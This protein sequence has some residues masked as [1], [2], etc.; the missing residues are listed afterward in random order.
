MSFLNL[1]PAPVQL[2]SGEPQASSLYIYSIHVIN[3]VSIR[4]WP[5]YHMGFAS[6]TNWNAT[7]ES[8]IGFCLI[9]NI[10]G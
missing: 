10:V 6:L 2:R 9:A 3:F 8:M 1:S 4:H 7:P 5:S